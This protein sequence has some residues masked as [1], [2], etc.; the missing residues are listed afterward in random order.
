[1]LFQNGRFCIIFYAFDF[2]VGVYY[3]VDEKYIA[4]CP[5][6]MLVFR[7]DFSLKKTS[8][9]KKLKMTTTTKLNDLAKQIHE[10]AK[11][12]GFYDEPRNTGELFMLMVS[13]LAEALEADREGRRADIDVYLDR[14]SVHPEGEVY[15]FQSHI[16]DTLEDEIADVVIRVLDYCAFS[17]I[18]IS[19]DLFDDIDDECNTENIGEYLLSITGSLFYAS[20]SAKGIALQQDLGLYQQVI[21][22]EKEGLSMELHEAIAKLFRLAE[23]LG[24]GL[25][26]HIELKMKYNATREHKHGKKY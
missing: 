15:F 1:M 17:N 12:K 3:D 18:V 22:E 11:A 13:E 8:H 24:F 5:L 7:W 16:K 9:I 10:N 14:L 6:P 26:Q 19:H 21:T 25:L 4:V 2:W 20:I 23:T